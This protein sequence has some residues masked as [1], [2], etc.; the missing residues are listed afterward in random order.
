VGV[1]EVLEVLEVV[2][3]VRSFVVCNM[4]IKE[5]FSSTNVIHTRTVVSNNFDGFPRA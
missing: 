4:E 5:T 1:L 3:K 2:G